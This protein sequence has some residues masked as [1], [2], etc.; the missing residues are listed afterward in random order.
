[1]SLIASISGIRGTVGGKPGEGL[2]PPNVVRF[3][4][5]YGRWLQETNPG[6]RLKVVTGRDARVSGEMIADLV[7]A[8][9]M[10]MGI[11]VVDLGLAATPTVE[12]AVSGLQAA[13]GIIITASHN[14]AEWNALKLLNSK[15]E[16]LSASDGQKILD[17]AAHENYTYCQVDALGNLRPDTSWNSKHV[18]MVCTNGLVNTGAITAAGLT[19]VL[20]C[21]NSVG[22]LIMPGLL[23]QL[24]VA[25]IIPLYCEPNGL[26]PHN[27]EPLPAHL[28]CL[29]ETVLREK[30]D[31]G[32]AVDPDVDR[33]A[34]VCED[35]SMFGE[36]YS[37]VAAA[38]YVLGI[39]PGSTVSNMSSSKALKD[40]TEKHGCSYYSS[41]VG[42]VNVVSEMKKRE[43]VIGGEGNGGIILPAIHYG[44]DALVGAAL[45]LSYL[46]VRGMR[47]SEIRQSLPGYYMYKDKIVTAHNQDMGGIF[48]VLKDVFAGSRFDERDG[49]RIDNERGWVHIRAS[50]TEP[51]VR[52]YS[53]AVTETEAKELGSIVS[54]VVK[55]L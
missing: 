33:L 47:C 53:E 3:T 32:I 9:L 43:A 23:R 55:K 45:F 14:P 54:A 51:V 1:M 34:I 6:M 37:L 38:D 5:A 20:D 15:G 7:N 21:V 52:I 17:I 44:R 39:S 16:F 49:L 50:N 19:V 2:T 36:E 41:P 13:G 42:E 24:G 31:L 27:P 18:D 4:S 40:I 25:K 28:S 8:S 35:G 10:L 29:S 26:F 11:D 46:S 12:L 22:G 30:A 48:S